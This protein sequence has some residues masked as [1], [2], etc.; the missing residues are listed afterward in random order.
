MLH[1]VVNLLVDRER[2]KQ[3]ALRRNTKIKNFSMHLYYENKPA[4]TKLSWKISDIFW[5]NGTESEQDRNKYIVVYS[6]SKYSSSSY[7]H[8]YIH[9]YIHSLFHCSAL[10]G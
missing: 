9:T 7:L 4:R 1:D 3:T 8:T 6:S 2:V 5:N 10:L